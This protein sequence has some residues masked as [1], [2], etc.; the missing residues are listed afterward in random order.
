MSYSMIHDKRKE[1]IIFS[2]IENRKIYKWIDDSNVTNCYSC[3]LTFNFYYRKHH[4]RLCGRIFCY[5]CSEKTIEIPNELQIKP[6]LP[7]SINSN[8]LPKYID[9]INGN[10]NNDKVRVCD[11]CYTKITELNKLKTLI[12]IFDIM[13]FTIPELLVLRCVNRQWRQ[14]SNY[15]LSRIR[16]I[17]YYLSDHKYTIFD[18]KVLWSNRHYIMGHSQWVIQLLKSIDYEDYTTTKNKLDEINTLITKST[19]QRILNCKRLMCTRQCNKKLVAEDCLNLLN[20]SIKSGIIK[21]YIIK[22]LDSANITELTCYIPYFVHYMKYETVENSIIGNY[23]IDKCIK[24]SEPIDQKIDSKKIIFIN[25]FYWQMKLGLEDKLCSQIYKYFIDKLEDEINNNVMKLIKSGNNLVSIFDNISQSLSEQDIKIYIKK[26]ISKIK[27]L[28]IPINPIMNNIEI[29]I[30]DIHVKNSATKPILLPLKYKLNNETYNYSILYKPEDIRK[31]KIVLNIIKL[32]DLI[33]KKEEKLDLNILTYGVRPINHKSGFIEFVPDCQTIYHIKEKMNFSISNYIFE[34]NRD[35]PIHIVRDRFMKS[36]AAYCVITYL[37]GIGDRH[38]ENIMVTKSGIL[39]HIDYG[40]ILGFDSK[41]MTPHMR[42]TEDMVDALG[43]S[44]SEC[45]QEFKNTCN[46]VYNCMRRHINLFINML[47]LLSEIDP[48]IDNKYPF[49]H[50]LIKNELLKRFIPGENNDIAE[51]HLY[52]HID[53][54]SKDYKY[55][56]ADFMHY[57]NQENVISNTINTG[58]DG[59]KSIIN[60]VYSTIFG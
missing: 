1:D 9:N 25:E 40:F 46:T 55:I 10:K 22:Y 49:S 19:G 7:D 15:F 60:G 13:N 59:A 6:K 44:N 45:Y 18:K 30:S 43:G 8:I 17:Q 51:L 27:Q 34:N 14:V 41:M 2:E 47:S 36:C 32:I 16:E 11:T 4:C 56:L 26:G 57:C 29:N 24:Y 37:L 48:I 5:Q 42:I 39:F 12:L 38:L 23:F 28:T 50:D 31:D 53:S 33:L 54:S 58:Y 35:E 21:Q 20:R 52:N 3:N